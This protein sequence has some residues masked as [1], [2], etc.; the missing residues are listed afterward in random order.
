M[1]TAPNPTT[2]TIHKARVGIT[3]LPQLGHF[4]EFGAST[5]IAEPPIAGTGRCYS[6]DCKGYRKSST[7]NYCKCEHHWDRHQ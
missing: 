2:N 7:M 3:L 4:S 1:I 5:D 6:C